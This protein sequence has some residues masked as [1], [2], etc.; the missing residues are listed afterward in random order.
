MKNKQSIL[1]EYMLLKWFRGDY[2]CPILKIF[3]RHSAWNSNRRE[4]LYGGDLNGHVCKE[5]KDYNEVHNG[6]NFENRNDKRR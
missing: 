3:R 4:D 6:F 5:N 1:L 2:K